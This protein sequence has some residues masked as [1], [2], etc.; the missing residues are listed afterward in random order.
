MGGENG[1]E[2]VGEGR[3]KN[4]RWG[5]EGG[6]VEVERRRM[7]DRKGKKTRGEREKKGVE[8]RRGEGGEKVEEGVGR[9]EDG[10]EKILRKR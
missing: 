3:E 2:E 6:E 9:I 1:G 8:R 5:R 10:K 7:G 4:R